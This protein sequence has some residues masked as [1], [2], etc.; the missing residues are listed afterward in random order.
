MAMF[1]LHPYS[2]EADIQLSN[3]KS[4]YKYLNTIIFCF[5]QLVSGLIPVTWLILAEL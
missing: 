4:C 3:L 1:D 2:L 5:Q